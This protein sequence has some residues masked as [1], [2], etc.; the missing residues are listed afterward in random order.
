MKKMVLLVVV[1][2]SMALLVASL[3]YAEGT[4]T[5]R[6]QLSFDEGDSYCYRSYKG[7]HCIAKADVISASEKNGTL[8]LVVPESFKISF[9]KPAKRTKG[10]AKS[11]EQL[12][13]AELQ[14]RSDEW[15]AKVRKSKQEN[16]GKN[17]YK[18]D[19]V[20]DKIRRTGTW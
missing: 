3:V 19:R 12:R 20:I 16:S 1:V 6:W 7:K 9:A 4:K 13:R 11:P 17:R 5:L 14:R 18:V 8:I 2:L 15:D 10:F